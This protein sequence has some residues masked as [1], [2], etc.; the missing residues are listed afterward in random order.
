M[1]D[2]PRSRSRHLSHSS[3]PGACDHG[4]LARGQSCPVIVRR[5]TTI[6]ALEGD[7]LVTYRDQALA[8]LADSTPER[9]F[10]IGEAEMRQ[11]DHRGVLFVSAVRGQRVR[12]AVLPPAA[13]RVA[14]PAMA[15][16]RRWLARCIPYVRHLARERG[17]A[18]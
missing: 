6:V 7:L 9:A 8:W 3:P 11:I 4:T 12:Y 14:G 10:V 2:T 17:G 13:G 18:Q 16:L 5:G 15:L 1:L